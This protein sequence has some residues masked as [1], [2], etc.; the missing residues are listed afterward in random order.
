MQMVS[1]DERARG[2]ARVCSLCGRGIQKPQD[3]VITG[4]SIAH[5]GCLVHEPDAALMPAEH[6]RLVRFC[7]D[8]VVAECQSC[9]RQHRLTELVTDAGGEPRSLR[10]PSCR[11]GLGASLR[12]HLATCFVVRVGVPRWQAAFR[13]ALEFVRINEA[14][15]RLGGASRP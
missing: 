13:E 9:R 6:T 7:F 4:L 15:R 2:P 5:K 1:S 10:C 3:L 8:H 14:N 11:R 12:T